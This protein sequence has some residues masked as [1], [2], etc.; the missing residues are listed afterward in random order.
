MY[1]RWSRIFWMLN[2]L[3]FLDLLLI[4]LSSTYTWQLLIFITAYPIYFHDLLSFLKNVIFAP[5]VLDM[6][7]E[8]CF[9]VY[10]G[11]GSSSNRYMCL[12]RNLPLN[13]SNVT[14]WN[15]GRY[16]NISKTVVGVVR[17]APAISRHARLWSFVDDFRHHS[18]DAYYVTLG[19]TTWC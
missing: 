10:L 9:H 14:I 13:A 5:Q 2:F 8:Y 11:I 16:Y 15:G 17:I 12:A 4:L 19:I 18:E 3:L 1:C 6:Q 7:I